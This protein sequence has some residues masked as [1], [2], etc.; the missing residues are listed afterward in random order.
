MKRLL[1]LG[2][3]VCFGFITMVAVTVAQQAQRGD[4]PAGGVPQRGAGGGGGGV[5]MILK[6]AENLYMIPGAGGNTA[7]YVADNGVVLVDTKNPNNGQGILDQV[8]TVTSK[9]VTHIINTHTHGDHTGSNLFFP[10]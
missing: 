6:V 7:V 8:K 1:V 2:L 10:A 3:I 9:P 4:A 5:G